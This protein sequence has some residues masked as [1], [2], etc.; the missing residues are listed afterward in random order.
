MLRQSRTLL[1]QTMRGDTALFTSVKGRIYP[2][3][4]ATLKDPS[5]PCI[6]FSFNSG[7]S[8]ENIPALAEVSV[9]LKSYSVK[10]Y[11]E[12]WDIYE[13]SRTLLLFGVFEDSNVRIRVTE[14]NTPTERYDTVGNVYIVIAGL[15]LQIIEV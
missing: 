1:M 13:K 7:A 14:S 2:Q 11:D 3:D 12:A 9:S 8:D 6:T 4:I 5:Y 10:S 15:D